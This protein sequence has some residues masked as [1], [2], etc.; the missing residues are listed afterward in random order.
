[1]FRHSHQFRTSELPII[2][3]SEMHVVP[4]GTLII[5][6]FHKEYDTFIKNSERCFIGVHNTQ[7]I[8]QCVNDHVS[9]ITYPAIHSWYESKRNLLTKMKSIL[10]DV[11]ALTDLFGKYETDIVRKADMIRMVFLK[12]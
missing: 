1:M 6:I 8:I 5:Y 4:L 12:Y 9:A 10:S 2:K 7:A 11:A 3:V